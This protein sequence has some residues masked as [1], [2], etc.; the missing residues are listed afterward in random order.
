MRAIALAFQW[1]PGDAVVKASQACA[2]A[3][4][5][6]EVESRGALCFPAATCLLWWRAREPIGGLR[7]RFGSE[8]P[9]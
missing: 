5:C 4:R 1:G 8:V 9:A 7:C 6:P 2:G 3:P